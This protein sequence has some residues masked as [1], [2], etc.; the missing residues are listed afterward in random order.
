[1]ELSAL[2]TQRLRAAVDPAAEEKLIVADLRSLGHDLWSFD[3]NGDGGAWCADWTRPAPG[4]TLVLETT[5]GVDP[6]SDVEAAAR[7]SFG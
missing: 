4:P 3:D 7:V 6:E 1:M 5:L 2:L